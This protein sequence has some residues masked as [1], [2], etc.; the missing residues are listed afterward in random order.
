MTLN[1]DPDRVAAFRAKMQEVSDPHSYAAGTLTVT[2]HM[3]AKLHQQDCR[4]AQP[5]VGC[6]ICDEIVD[7]LSMVAAI[8]LERP[9]PP[10]AMER[11]R[12]YL[13]EP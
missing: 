4:V 12:D 9:P 1:P 10:E 7:G 6:R 11:L 13:D 3:I 8:Q 2:T 5:G